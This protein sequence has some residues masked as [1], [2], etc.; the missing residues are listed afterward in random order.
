MDEFPI[1]LDKAKQIAFYNLG[2]CCV[3]PC[4]PLLIKNQ[5][6]VAQTQFLWLQPAVINIFSL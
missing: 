6:A 4:P 2:K 5:R 3:C 1:F